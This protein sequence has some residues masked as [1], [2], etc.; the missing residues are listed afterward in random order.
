MILASIKQLLKTAFP[1]NASAVLLRL[2]PNRRRYDKDT[3]KIKSLFEKGNLI[4]KVPHDR[5]PSVRALAWAEAKTLGV[6]V[7]SRQVKKSK[8]HTTIRIW[9]VNNGE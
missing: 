6:K 8:T 4:V 1:V 9:I 2:A 7:A 5:I 3:Y